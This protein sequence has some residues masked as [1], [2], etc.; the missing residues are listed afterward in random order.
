M[1]FSS[2]LTKKG[3]I[4][5]IRYEIYAFDSDSVTTGTIVTGLQE[6][7]HKNF[8]NDVTEGDGKLTHSASTLTLAGLTSSDTGTVIVFG[9]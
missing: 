7:Y 5:D 4:G 2:T 1:A 8:N 9:V 3:I 6:I